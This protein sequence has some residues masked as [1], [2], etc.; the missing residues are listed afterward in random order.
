MNEAGKDENN[1]SKLRKVPLDFH[2]VF[3]LISV[4]KNYLIMKL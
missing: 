4:P 3:P 1:Q 2:V